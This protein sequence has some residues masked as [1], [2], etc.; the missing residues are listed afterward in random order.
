MGGFGSGRPAGKGRQ[1]V[2]SCRSL[3]IRE[4]QRSGCLT[5]GWH[6]DLQWQKA[7][8]TIA[9][10]GLRFDGARLVL[11]YRATSNDGTWQDV[12][13]P[14]EIVQRP[15][16]F[17]GQRPYF[18][19]PGVVN[20]VACQRR[21]LK[22]YGPGR[23]FLCRHCCRLAYA[24]Q[25]EGALDRARRRVTKLR[26][27]LRDESDQDSNLPTRPNGMWN[28]T[29]ARLANKFVAAEEV[30][31]REF[32]RSIGVVAAQLENRNRKASFWS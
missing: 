10:I 3:D 24:S 21:A 28:R 20:G 22:L 16:R 12:V 8:E 14:I 7:G 30:A 26:R 2:E 1:T 25:S 4:L 11:S 13:G 29:Y 32:M 18:V 19:C 23:Y 5:P 6:G 31:D 15:C 27:Q 9:S 17:G